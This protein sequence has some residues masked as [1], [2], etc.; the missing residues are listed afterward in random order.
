MRTTRCSFALALLLT[1][2]IA[3]GQEVS[4]KLPEPDAASL[5]AFHELLGSEP[6][7]AGTPGDQ[8]TIDRLVSAFEGMGLE[9]EVHEFWPLLCRPIEAHL[10]IVQ[11]A[12][13][14]SAPSPAAA[15][16]QP[17]AT[18]RGV[19][20]LSVRED[21]LLEDPATAHPD[22]TYGWNAYSGSGD[23]TAEVVYANYGTKAD[24]QKLQELGV[25]CK[26]RIVLARYGGNFRG[27]KAKFAEEAGMRG[28]SFSPTLRIPAMPRVSP[29]QK[30]AGQTP[31]AFNAALS[32]R[33]P[34]WAIH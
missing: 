12:E 31:V 11:H 34:T 25:A 6:H 4:Q 14:P 7:I 18:R 1:A 2:V 15:T 21:N 22:L 19:I 28:S 27:Y 9:V 23:V 33:C 8:R 5:R 24:F 3:S 17:Q 16:T 32:S 29:T 26:G 13:H 10:E 20:S 30:A